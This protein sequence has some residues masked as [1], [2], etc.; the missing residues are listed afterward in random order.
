MQ[1]VALSLRLLRLTP[2]EALRL[3]LRQLTPCEALWLLLQ[4]L[5]PCEAL[6]LLLQ[7]LASCEALWLLQLLTPCEVLWLLRSLRLVPCGRAT[8]CSHRW[9]DW[10]ASSPPGAR[11]LLL[12][13]ERALRLAMTPER[14]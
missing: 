2:C 5:T 10:S 11:H 3:L 14:S 9:R 8:S 1:L 13:G 6:W 7:L 4:L 12:P